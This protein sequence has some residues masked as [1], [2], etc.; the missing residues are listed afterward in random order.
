MEVKLSEKDW[1]KLKEAQKNFTND[2]AFM[3]AYE[4]GLE[5]ERGPDALIVDLF[6][7]K[8]A[9]DKGKALSDTFGEKSAPAF[10]LWEDFHKVWTVVRT[11]FIDDHLRRVAEETK[12]VQF[13]NVGAGLDTRCFRLDFAPSFSK[14]F[15][16]D[17]E[18]IN[19]PKKEI[20]AALEMKPLCKEHK[21][22]SVDLKI[23]GALEKGEDCFCCL[24]FFLK[25]ICNFC[26]F[27]FK[28]F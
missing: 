15:E 9:G 6:A 3:I 16:I 24:N 20:F 12:G 10:G 17:M 14:A 1:E 2:S 4:R 11:K 23:A 18:E 7:S 22:V 8:L 21:L 19:V 13:V 5:T 27:G 25:K 26:S 28:R